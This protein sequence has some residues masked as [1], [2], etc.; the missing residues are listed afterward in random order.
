MASEV[1]THTYFGRM[2]VI[3]RN[4]SWHA[5]CSYVAKGVG[6]WEVRVRGGVESGKSLSKNLQRSLTVKT[7]TPKQS[8]VRCEAKWTQLWSRVQ[9]LDAIHLVH[10]TATI[11]SIP[12]LHSVKSLPEKSIPINC[13]DWMHSVMIAIEYSYKLGRK[14]NTSIWLAQAMNSSPVLITTR[15]GTLYC[16]GHFNP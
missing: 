14:K 3:I 7:W 13:E 12:H 5:P 2:K 6:E 11:V 1:Y 15:S 8:I 16:G 9:S 10:S 4:C